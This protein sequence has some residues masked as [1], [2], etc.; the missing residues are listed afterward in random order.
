MRDQAAPTKNETTSF[1]PAGVTNNTPDTVAPSVTSGSADGSMITLIFSEDL[2][3]IAAD[4]TAFTVH[5]GATTRSVTNVSMSGKVLSLTIS[6]AVTS[7]DSVSV[8]YAIPATNGLH[9][10]AANAVAPFTRT[11]ANQ[12]P[13]V[14]PP[15]SG[16]S[17]VLAPVLVSAS[18][19]DGATVHEVATITLTANQA[20]TW[21]QMTV[22][23]PD[24]TTTPLGD[25]SGQ[26]ATWPLPNAAAGLYTVR[27]TVA[28]GGRS[29]DVL[30]HFTIWTPPA[31]GPE[32][33][34]PPVQKNA[35]PF[36]AGELKSSDGSTR[37]VW[38]AGAFSDLVVVEIAQAS[39]AQVKNVPAG[40]TVVNVTAFL[41]ST[42]APVKDLGGVIDI[43]FTN[44]GAG[45]HPLTSADGSTWRDIPQLQT[46]NLPDGA[47]DGWF[48]DSDGTVHVLARHLTW[49]A[50]VGPSAAT[51][52]AMRII[53]V[54]RL[55]LEH[56][57]FVAVRMAITAPARVT[58]NFVGPDGTIVPGQT[59]KTPTRHAGVTILRVPLK[60]TRPGL[61][62]LQM[63]ADGLGQTVDRT[64]KIRFLATRPASPVWQDGAIRVAV[65]TGARGLGGL[66]T[67]LGSHFVVKK[68]SDA[69]LYSVVDTNYRTAAA[70]IVVD[71]DTVPAYTLAGL[72]AL[73]PEVKI[74]GLSSK[75]GYRFGVS[76]VL[77]RGSSAATVAQTVKSLLR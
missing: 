56:R 55:W 72:H 62:R 38:P 35:V 13:I 51:K 26:A 32:G 36:A 11:L 25:A 22:T 20:V 10:A 58:G 28:A 9:D 16:G 46:L 57:S 18:P 21:S 3:G 67:K 53:S 27:G 59:I 1:G 61:Y 75:G 49:Y 43:R 30:T 2:A 60:I 34:V 29:A 8:S 6:P 15:S 5:V 64:A 42:H 33:D 12:T 47:A 71:L 39:T 68:V 65:V 40:A 44:A 48:R 23:R 70:A 54:R 7:A 69:D 19:E 41:R 76:A 37:I 52:L 4:P 66:G 14:V 77:P 17:A 74:V 50:L 31:S 24:G 45:S 63:H 73:L